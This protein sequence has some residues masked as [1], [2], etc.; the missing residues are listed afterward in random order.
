MHKTCQEE[1][2]LN[3]APAGMN[4]CNLHG[5]SKRL[6]HGCSVDLS[7]CAEVRWDHSSN[8]PFCCYQCARA[9]MAKKENGSLP[10]SEVM[11]EA[12][13]TFKA[14]Q[15]VY[16]DNYKLAAEALKA[17][18]PD[19]VDLKT[20]EDQERYHIFMLIVVKLSRYANGWKSPH[21]DSIHDAGIYSFMLEA[22]DQKQ[23]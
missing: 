15:A 21:Q 11:E 3:D 18:F 16:G 10:V 20:S 23:K 1:H 4:H 2:C 13:K 6:C 8:E 22:I 7:G 12:S 19:G 9:F 17:F 5:F 14:R